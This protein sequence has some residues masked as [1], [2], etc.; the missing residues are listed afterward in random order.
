MRKSKVAKTE[1]KNPATE[2]R[3]TTK[4]L[5]LN[6]KL[7]N[8]INPEIIDAIAMFAVPKDVNPDLNY[9]DLAPQVFMMVDK[10]D[11]DIN[12]IMDNDINYLPEY[13]LD[14]RKMLFEA[15]NNFK[16]GIIRFISDQIN[17][18]IH[19][20]L[21]NP[22]IC[23]GQLYDIIY[24]TFSSDPRDYMYNSE[25]GKENNVM[26]LTMINN[27]IP[28]TILKINSFLRDQL[29]T[30]Y[31]VNNLNIDQYIEHDQ[32]VSTEEMLENYEIIETVIE[33]ISAITNNILVDAYYKIKNYCNDL[34]N[35]LGYPEIKLNTVDKNKDK[36]IDIIQF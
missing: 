5:E 21:N 1:I 36:N 24:N 23:E 11:A 35:P 25:D 9:C 33:N 32:I 19:T 26:D 8:S 6:E 22:Y 14:R 10:N 17:W 27:I 31:K 15:Y 18:V 2:I 13:I 3:N 16:Q 12:Y 29:L 4:V 30:Y 28:T 7:K 34:I 20:N